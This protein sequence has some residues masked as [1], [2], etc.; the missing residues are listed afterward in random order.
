MPNEKKEYITKTTPKGEVLFAHIDKPNMKF[1]KNGVGN[2]EVDLLLD[3]DDPT[4][5]PFL[6][7]LQKI[8][9]ETFDAGFAEAKTKA[10]TPKQKAELSEWKVSCRSRSTTTRT[11]T[12]LARS[13]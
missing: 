5:Q 9:Q 10:K 3:V 7:Q 11:A 2:Y 12:R 8:G 1:A 6:D 4:V 13:A